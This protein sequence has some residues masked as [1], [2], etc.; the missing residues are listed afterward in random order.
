[1]T[2]KR[3][4]PNTKKPPASKLEQEATEFVRLKNTT[5]KVPEG[6]PTSRDSLAAAVLSGLLARGGSNRAEELVEEAY[7]YV[8]LLLRYKK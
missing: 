1:M 2:T 7:K 6:S 3:K 4:A 8:D 5:P